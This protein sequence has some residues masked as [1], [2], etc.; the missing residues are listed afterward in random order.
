MHTE[1]HIRRPPLRLGAGVLSLFCLLW[2]TGCAGPQ[3]GFDVGASFRR[4]R[5]TD[6]LVL[7]YFRSGVCRFCAQMDRE[8]F[9]DPQVRKRLDEFIL[10]QRD[11]GLWQAEAKRYGVSG[12]PGFVVHRPNG[13]VVGPPAVG[14]MSPAE[15]RAFLAAA[16]LQR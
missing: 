12:T 5:E 2:L 9:T 4:A 6:R 15:F 16:K 3:W 13:S 14:A 10:L 8:V 1:A 7:V 11:F